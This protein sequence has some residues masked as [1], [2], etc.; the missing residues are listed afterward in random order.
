MSKLPW[1]LILFLIKST[2][3]DTHKLNLSRYNLINRTTC[4]DEAKILN[5]FYNYRKPKAVF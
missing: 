5:T 4:T 3:P 1:A 2:I